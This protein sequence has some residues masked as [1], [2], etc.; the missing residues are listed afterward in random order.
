MTH[1]SR[2]EP[3]KSAECEP[4]R[5]LTSVANEPSVAK[6]SHQCSK[7]CEMSH[8]PPA[9]QQPVGCETVR[10][11]PSVLQTVRKQT[12][13]SR[14]SHQ[15]AA[16]H[17]PRNE[18]F[19]ASL[20]IRRLRQNANHTDLLT[21]ARIR[22]L[23]LCQAR[24]GRIDPPHT[25]NNTPRVKPGQVRWRDAPGPTVRAHRVSPIVR[26]NPLLRLHGPPRCVRGHQRE[27]ALA[28]LFRLLRQ[29]GGARQCKPTPR[30]GRASNGPSPREGVPCRSVAVSEFLAGCSGGYPSDG[31]E[32]G[33]AL[34][35]HGRQ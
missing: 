10:N 21:S 17:Q 6:M 26:Q 18:Q 30:P 15:P 4:H 22:Q 5:R 27:Q 33:P 2:T 29:S 19:F 28:T 35:N 20:A 9:S 3:S 32:G 31:S 12:H 24:I 8:Q 23:S 7:Q 34:A 13:I 1:Q 25:P 11:E 14:M 16:S